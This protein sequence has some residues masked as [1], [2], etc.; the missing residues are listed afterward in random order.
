ME[1]DDLKNLDDVLQSLKGKN[2][3]DAYDYEGYAVLDRLELSREELKQAVDIMWE[4]VMTMDTKQREGKYLFSKGL[5]RSKN[6]F[7]VQKEKAELLTGEKLDTF[8][9]K[10]DIFRERLENAKPLVNF[11]IKVKELL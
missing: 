7:M 1:S 2:I 5:I 10:A 3:K 11:L 9:L 6:I 8:N 4:I